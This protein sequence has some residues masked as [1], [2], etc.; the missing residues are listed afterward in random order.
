MQQ[1]YRRTFMPM[2][3]FNKVALHGCSPVNFLHIFRTLFW[4]NTTGGLL[5][6]WADNELKGTCHI[7]ISTKL[8]WTIDAILGFIQTTSIPSFIG[9]RI[10]TL[11]CTA[12]PK[13][14]TL[15]D[16]YN[17]LKSR[18]T[19]ILVF[20]YPT[21]HSILQLTSISTQQ[22]FDGLQDV[23]KTSSTHVLKMS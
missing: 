11:H 20:L 4:K 14:T 23:L 17:L 19:I 22:I 6:R 1:I 10:K 2:C 18:K 3:D 9:V 21:T 7:R 13:S 5:L 16:L 8:F 12:F 15:S